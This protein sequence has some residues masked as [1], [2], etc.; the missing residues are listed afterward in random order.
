MAPVHT[1]RRVRLGYAL[2][3]ALA[4]SVALACSVVLAG[5]VQA[6]EAAMPSVTY[7]AIDQDASVLIAGLGRFSGDT[8][9]ADVELLAAGIGS[10]Q[11]TLSLFNASPAGCRQ[12]LCFA[13]DCWWADGTDGTIALLTGA[14]L[15]RGVLSVRSISSTLQHQ[16]PVLPLV[17]RLMAPWLGGQAGVSYL[18][19]EGQWT[20]T[21]DDHGHQHLVEILSLCE[22]PTA[23]ASSRVADADLPDLRRLTTSELSVQS[24]PA[25]VEGLTATMQASVALAPRLR[26][27]TFP[28][29]GVKLRQ[30]SRAEVVETLRHH[31]IVARWSHGVLCLGDNTRAAALCDREH[32]AQRR[33]LALIPIGH[34]LSTAV[35]GELIITAIRRRVSPA[36]WGLSGAGIEFLSGSGT[37]LVA[38]DLDTQQAVLDAVSAIDRLGLELGLRTLDAGTGH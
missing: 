20:A 24:W 18:P 12:A 28:G 17:E 36:W 6:G 25:L 1:P 27:R 29:E 13:L 11:A 15:P 8:Y 32:P 31:G 9:Q 3:V 16:S 30:Q 5:P 33:R 2:S 4:W 10:T 22:R 37:L 7:A 23:R 21:L 14:Q 34:L 26:L 38:S 19:S 35:D